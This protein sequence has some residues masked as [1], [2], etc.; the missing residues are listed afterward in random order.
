MG[1]NVEV[2][3]LGPFEVHTE[4]GSPVALGGL[5]QR[6][7]LALLALRANEVVSTDKLIDEIWGQEA[8]AK[9]LHTIQVFVSR[10]R[11]ALGLASGRLVTQSPGYILNLA[12]EELDASRFERMLIG[13]RSALAMGSAAE[14]VALLTDAMALWR[15]PPLADFTYEPFAQGAIARLDELRL[16]AREDLI[17]AELALGRHAEVVPELEAIIHEQPFRERPRGQLMLAL[18]RCGRQAQA[19][20]AFQH[21]RRASIDELAI[22]PGEALRE[23]EQ[24]ILRQDPA[25]QLKPA[26]VVA[27]PLEPDSESEKDETQAPV[28]ASGELPEDAPPTVVRRTATVLVARVATS[29]P[30]DPEL[31][32]RSLARA[33]RLAEEIVAPHGGAFVAGLGGDWLWVFGLPVVREDDV[34]RALRA[35]E[36]L[37][38]RVQTVGPPDLCRLTIGIGLATGE[39]IA[40]ETGDLYGEPLNRAAAL[41]A[42]AKDGEI[43]LSDPTRRLTR[44]TAR[45]EST[46][47]ENSFR[48][49]ELVP[50][51]ALRPQDDRP[52]VGR[53]EELALARAIFARTRRAGDMH[54]MT[55]IGDAGIGKSRFAYEVGRRLAGEA[56]ILTGR[57]LSYGDGVAFW[58]LREAFTQF[59]GGESRDAIRALLNGCE[60]ADV[61]ADTVAGALGLMPAE[62]VG[63]QVLWAFRR[64]LEAL[65]GKKPVLLVLEDM[66]WAQPPLLG[67]VDYLVDW[68]RAP[69]LV[70]CLARPE[71]LELRPSWGGGHQRISSI[72]LPP[73]DDSNTLKLFNQ[74]PGA[75]VLTALQR[76]AILRAAEGN[77]LFVEQLLQ[78]S[79]ENEWWDREGQIPAT[80][81]SL[82]AAR[83]DRLGPGERAFIECAAVM[84]REFWPGAVTYLLPDEARASASQHMREL[85]H[86]GLIHPDRTTLGAEE[87]LRFHHILIRDVA[88]RTTPKSVRAELHE[89]FAEW[90]AP[91]GEQYDEFVGYHL[92]QAFRHHSELGRPA[93]ELS[94]LAQ[95]AADTLA[96]A[97]QRAASRGDADGAV[98]L[99]RSS[100][101][102]VAASNTKRPDILIEF[103]SALSES[104]HFTEAHQVLQEAI[105]QSRSAGDEALTAH[106]Q[107][108]LSYWR[109]RARPNTRASEMRAVAE[110]AIEVFSR[111]GDDDGLSHAW[112]HI[113]WVA[114]VQCRCGEMEAALERAVTHAERAG[115][116]RGHSQLLSD[117]ARATVMGPRPVEQALE[118]CQGLLAGAEGD[119]GAGA[120]IGAM[121]GVLEAMDG[122]IDEARVR[123]RQSKG[124]LEDIGLSFT[125]AVVQMFYAFIELASGDPARAEPE[126]TEACALFERTGDSGRLSSAA[127]LLARL[128]CAQGR[129]EEAARYSELSREAASDDDVVSQVVWRGSHARVLAHAGEASAAVEL[130][131]SAWSRIEQ[132]D[133]LMLQGDALCDRADVLLRLGQRDRVLEDLEQAIGLYERKGLRVAAARAVELRDSVTSGSG[134]S[135]VGSRPS[136]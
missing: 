10:L 111:A 79:S 19:L 85:V 46:L 51:R 65:P 112:H 2:R 54:L 77:P 39:I 89:R 87:Q 66:H 38:D 4:R 95:R 90:V 98:K 16:G 24:A 102:L 120:F 125:V 40:E 88:Y 27:P 31:A 41:G 22:E 60:D 9:A 96:R 113:A 17:D 42:A 23:L 122:R 80:I 28:V 20:D 49:L 118:R 69:I 92:E 13:A 103:G 107:I 109:S 48:L 132:T 14:A 61:I 7:V 106:A 5:R 15:G 116:R 127:A 3:I 84:G 63:D 33:R 129:Y 29:E 1:G 53:D 68:L 12:G 86:R 35:G 101:E 82:L 56:T 135:L 128:L 30:A 57:C 97:G 37:R 131:D 32:R 25:L 59:A 115:T 110:E 8:P 130:A 21:A 50:V 91:R 26:E 114:W 108:A 64:L 78:T 99:L 6:A 133:F 58:P 43:V 94:E 71:V 34:L 11:A 62:N 119:I 75:D 121:M 72:V 18:Y 76:E 36:A 104:R 126:V 134:A 70:A 124:R 136:T 45:V 123:W 47:D 83:L 74:Q 117:L 73:L 52:M 100:A 67:L 44:G 81:Q 105:P 93:V 55:V